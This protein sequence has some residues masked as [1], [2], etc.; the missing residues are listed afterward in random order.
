MILIVNKN[1]GMALLAHSSF[2]I[3]RLLQRGHP[4]RYLSGLLQHSVGCG[5]PRLEGLR[6]GLH[7]RHGLQPQASGQRFHHPVP[8][9]G[10]VHRTGAGYTHHHASG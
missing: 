7:R 10:E 3:R 1:I 2:S 4:D 8:Q 5:L 9:R 6:R